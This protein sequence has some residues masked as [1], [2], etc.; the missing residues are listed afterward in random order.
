MIK[1]YISYIINRFLPEPLS[2]HSTINS[3][4]SPIIAIQIYRNL[5]I[6]FPNTHD[7]IPMPHPSP[8]TCLRTSRFPLQRQ[9]SLHVDCSYSYYSTALDN[10]DISTSDKDKTPVSTNGV[11]A[12]NKEIL[13]DKICKLIIV[14]VQL[15]IDKIKTE[16]TRINLKANK[17]RLLNKKNF[18]IAKKK[19]FWTEIITL[20][21]INVLIRDY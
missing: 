1:P 2:R 20:N 3:Y 6:A 10:T 9:W 4:I 17:T 21:V 18:L 8:H 11:E 13:N 12:Y 14:N 19:E 5:S 15:M 7:T 16:K